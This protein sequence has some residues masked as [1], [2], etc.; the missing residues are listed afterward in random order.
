MI[1][2]P[3]SP[4]LAKQLCPNDTMDHM[5][6]VRHIVLSNLNKMFMLLHERITI[7]PLTSPISKA[8]SPPRSSQ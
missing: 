3:S 8:W 7:V 5:Q 2:W 1:I 4:P 6:L